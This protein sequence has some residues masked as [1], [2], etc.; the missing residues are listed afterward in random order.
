MSLTR[1]SVASQK[2]SGDPQKVL[3]RAN[4][5]RLI[6]EESQK[7]FYFGCQSTAQRD[8]IVMLVENFLLEKAQRPSQESILLADCS[9]RRTG[10]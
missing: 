10:A 2:C 8:C 4:V 9:L 1:V 6:L 3:A 5:F 7:I